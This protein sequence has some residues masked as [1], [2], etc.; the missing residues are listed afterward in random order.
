MALE[1]EHIEL[2]NDKVNEILQQVPAW[3]VR[4]GNVVI[5]FVVG[6]LFGV[7]YFIKYPDEVISRIV[8]TSAS[9]PKEIV[10]HPRSQSSE[11]AQLL[12]KDNEYVKKG[13]VLAVVSNP[14]VYKDIIQIDKEFQQFQKLYAEGKLDSIQSFSGN[15][16]LGIIQNSYSNLIKALEEY[17]LYNS[18]KFHR[19]NIEEVLGQIGTYNKL[20]E[21][22]ERERWITKQ[23]F[24]LSSSSFRR[25]S[26]LNSLGTYIATSTFEEQKKNYLNEKLKLE[27]LESQVLNTDLAIQLKKEAMLLISNDSIKTQQN[28]LVNLNSARIDFENQ[29]SSWKEINVLSSPINGETSFT[30]PLESGNKIE[31]GQELMLVLP[32]G[33]ELF[34]YTYIPSF[35]SGKVEV[36]QDV[37]IRFDGF[38]FKEYGMIKGKI[39]SISKVA[40]K[41][42]YYVQVKIPYNLETSFH[43]QISFSSNM[44]GEAHI[45][46]KN[47]RFIE[48]IFYQFRNV[49]SNG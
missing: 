41:G 1:P 24:K 40:V 21:S 37:K 30:H 39:S 14:A 2:K 23:H 15:L 6:V 42:N 27:R 17:K 45:I 43:K 46:T 20:K 26:I 8:V 29:L 47:L 7:A 3:T 44:Q 36:G 19:L 32:N 10:L 38:P 28:L 18:Y 16:Q 35:G 13:Q 48:R 49:F 4:W 33:N 25:D 9:L 22:L 31:A 12:V 11:I 34:A 5:L